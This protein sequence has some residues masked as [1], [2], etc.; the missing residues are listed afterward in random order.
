[1]K[2]CIYCKNQFL[3]KRKDQKYCNNNCK[4]KSWIKNN[5]KKVKIIRKKCYVYDKNKEMKFRYGITLNDFDFIFKKQKGLCAICGKKETRKSK[6]GKI[7]RLHI[8]HDHKTK[9]VRG[10]LCNKCNNGLGFFEDNQR[11][12]SNAIN[13]LQK[14]RTRLRYNQFKIEEPK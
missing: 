8:D 4:S 2:T 5:P 13:Y 12:L 3:P 9:K 11:Y 14:Q 10:L 6:N 1:M 7:Y